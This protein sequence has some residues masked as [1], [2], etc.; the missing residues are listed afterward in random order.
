M[1]FL[2]ILSLIHVRAQMNL[3]AQA[4][5]TYLSYLWWLLE[6]ILHVAMFYLVFEVFLLRGTPGFIYFLIIGKVPFL[7]VSKSLSSGANSIVANR[8]LMGQIRVPIALLPFTPLLEACYKQLFVMCVLV[9]FLVLTGVSSVSSA[10]W[11]LLPLTV[12]NFL[13]IVALTL[14]FAWLLAVVPDVQNL[15]PFITMF[16]MFTSG[17]FFDVRQIPDESIQ[18]LILTYNPLAF[19]IDGYRLIFLSDTAPQLSHLLWLSSVLLAI[20]IV[21]QLVFFSTQYFVTR[22]V[23]HA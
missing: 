3:K 20:S 19:L 16:L 12:V 21:T 14:P 11:W 1:K 17:I 7:W 4:A 9:A 13:F 15:L 6:P 5:Q 23:L 8:E 18:D 22:K 10:W 2:Q